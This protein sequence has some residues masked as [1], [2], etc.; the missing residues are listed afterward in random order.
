MPNL[1]TKD[2]T[3]T[4][5]VFGFA[6]MAL[7]VIKRLDPDYVCVAWD[8]PKTNIRKRLDI[9]PKYKANRKPAPPDF[10]AQI[11]Y[12]HELLEA[13]SWP[14]YELDDYEADDIMGTLAVKASKEGL[15]TVLVTS[16]MD[17]LQ[18]VNGNVK[19]YALKKGLSNIEEYQPESF[20]EKYG[21]N[22]DQFLDL[23]SIMGDSSDNIPGAPGI[24]EKGA[25]KLLN[26][27]K[28]LDGIYE[29]ID[30]IS[31]STHK[32]LVEGK[33]SAYMSKKLAELWLDAPVE[34]DLKSKDV[35]DNDSG[36]VMSILKKL[37]FKSLVRQLPDV[38]NVDT[39]ETDNTDL[40]FD[41]KEVK[42]E[43]IDDDAKAKK[44]K[45][46]N[47][48]PVTITGY[49]RGK[50]GSDPKYI[51]FSQN[52]KTGYVLDLEKLN[53]DAIKTIFIDGEIRII[54]YNTK[55]LIKIL[56]GYHVKNI[57]VEHDVLIGAFLINSLRR[58]QAL[59]DLARSDLGYDGGDLDNLDPEEFYNNAGRRLSVINSLFN[60][61][62]EAISELT[63]II[64]VASEVDF[65]VIPVL[66]KMEYAGIKLNTKYLNDFAEEL[67]DTISDLEQEIYGH[68]DQEFNISSPSQLAEV[69]FEKLKLPTSAKEAK[70]SKY[71]NLADLDRL[72]SIKKGKTGYSTAASEL[73][74]LRDMHPI[75]NLISQYREVTKLKNTY[76]DPLPEMVDDDSRLHTNFDMTT[77]QTGRLSSRDPNLQNIPVRTD[78]G[79][80]IRNAFEAEKGNVLI[81]ADYSQFELR[82][83]AVLASDENMIKAFNDDQDIHTLTA[84][85]VLGIKP[86]EVTK[87]QRYEAKAVNFGILYGQGPHALAEGTGMTFKQARDFINKYFE[88]RPKLK[89]YIEKTREQAK[90]KGYVETLLGRRR[91]TPDVKSS[92]FIVQGE[93]A[94]RA[95]VN[96]PLQ[97]SAADITKLAMIA[98]QNK[99]D[100]SYESGAMSSEPKLLLQIHDSILVECAEKDVET[101]SKIMK[102]AMEKVYKLPVKLKVDVDQGK[103]WGE[104]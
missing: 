29:N 24:G 11:P 26:E 14:L 41:I 30:L 71:K 52:E 82:L 5:G 44:I 7:E 2:G 68:A 15:E 54:G 50:Q 13:F 78:L 20:A 57:T 92:N 101:V 39:S 32:K 61:Q 33:D 51:A 23:K 88:V 3:P 49:A 43:L 74:K 79:K 80:K 19:V 93:G 46:D 28:T 97:G 35:T 85:D 83:A 64:K 87:Q 96:M 18:L 8:K 89:N 38:M 6:S 12:L 104:I 69:L 31:G 90:E 9:Y 76:V 53:K 67:E 16:D 102:E 58:E 56:L 95:A 62:A 21:I 99:F 59:T 73:A 22:V 100:Q 75:I 91:P 63:G 42:V 47:K 37:E 34:L 65:P 45:I 10:Y 60:Y 55:V 36:K 72:W 98:V 27:Y 48:K 40:N 17:I 86:E 103:N 4:G 84:S 81:S 94:Y 1:S 77:A 70:D 66:A 25:V